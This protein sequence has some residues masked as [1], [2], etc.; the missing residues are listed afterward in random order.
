MNGIAVGIKLIIHHHLRR[1]IHG[2]AYR[3]EAIAQEV[4]RLARG[5]FGYNHAGQVEVAV[6]VAR[7]DHFRQALNIQG[8]VS[9]IAALGL[10]HAIPH[11]IVM[12]CHLRC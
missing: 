1:V 3:T 4:A 10:P 7:L 5:A 6:A 11:T 2:L 12:I 8:K 9:C